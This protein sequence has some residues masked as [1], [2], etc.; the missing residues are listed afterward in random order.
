MGR[1]L[2]RRWFVLERGVLVEQFVDPNRQGERCPIKDVVFK[3][4][5]WLLFNA[6]R[7][8]VILNTPIFVQKGIDLRAPIAITQNLRPTHFAG[9]DFVALRVVDVL[10][11]QLHV[12]LCPLVLLLEE[13]LPIVLVPDSF[14]FAPE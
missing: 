1:E 14:S 8:L 6:T 3:T 7:S 2:D 9:D 12:F 13:T 11:Q 5:N 10:F 4:F